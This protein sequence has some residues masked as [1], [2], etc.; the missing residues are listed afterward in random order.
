MAS[1]PEAFVTHVSQSRVRVKIPG[2]KND[3]EYFSQLKDYLSPL[4]GVEKVEVNP[5]TGSVLVLHR[6]DL[7]S[8]EDLK[9]MAAYSEMT[10]LFKLAMLPT[11]NSVSIAQSLAD[12][13]AGLNENVKELSSG[14]VDVPTLAFVGLL[15]VSIVQMSEGVVAVPAITALW[16]A[17][18]ILKDQLQGNREGSATKKQGG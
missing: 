16:Y 11:V 4:P 18:S 5:L 10:G 12:G 8:L 6:L 13:F 17:S 2:K 9:S 15:A 3:R 7:K 1:L 14:I